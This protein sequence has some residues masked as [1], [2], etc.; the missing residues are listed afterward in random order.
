ML[1]TF[2]LQDGVL[3]Y[4]SSQSYWVICHEDGKVPPMT[5]VD[6]NWGLRPMTA[7]WKRYYCSICGKPGQAKVYKLTVS[8]RGHGECDRRCLEA[9]G[10]ECNCRCLSRCHGAGECACG[11]RSA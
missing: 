3:V 4:R 1:P 2:T 7:G 5:E 9:T 11:V 6:P 8:K 10:D